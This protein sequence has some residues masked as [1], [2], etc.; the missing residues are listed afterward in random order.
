VLYAAVLYG[1]LMQKTVGRK[2]LTEAAEFGRIA[3]ATAAVAVLGRWLML[4]TPWLPDWTTAGG[5]LLRLSA[6]G[7]LV[8]GAAF[9]VAFALGSTTARGI[10]RIKDI[11]KPPGTG[12]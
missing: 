10:H 12:A 5:A 1:R 8:F 9:L 3:M 6:G 11:L 4:G 2:G 7:V